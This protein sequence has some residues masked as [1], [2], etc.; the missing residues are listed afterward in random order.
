MSQTEPPIHPVARRQ[1]HELALCFLSIFAA[2]RGKEI[3][4][5]D[6]LSLPR[7]L[8]PSLP[9]ATAPPLHRSKSDV[10]GLTLRIMNCRRLDRCSRGSQRH[11]TNIGEMLR[12]GLNICMSTLIH[13]STAKPA[14]KSDE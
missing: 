4:R 11:L 14:L 12:R 10:D 1:R 3:A 7:S 13:T 9:R 2:R 5:R 6:K 8:A